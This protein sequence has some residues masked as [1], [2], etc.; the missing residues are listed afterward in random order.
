[1]WSARSSQREY[2]MV[3]CQATFFGGA[4]LGFI[5]LYPSKEGTNGPS[6]QAAM[7]ALSAVQWRESRPIQHNADRYVSES[8]RHAR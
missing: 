6:P 5:I 2:R 1:M 7:N 4:S 3:Q 8:L